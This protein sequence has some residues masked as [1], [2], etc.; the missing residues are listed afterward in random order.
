LGWGAGS[1]SAE[2]LAE[3]LAAGRCP[4]CSAAAAAARAL[5]TWSGAEGRTPN[6]L[7]DFD[8]LCAAHLWD[9]AWIAPRAAMQALDETLRSWRTSVLRLPPAEALPAPHLA[10]RVLEMARTW[11]PRLPF[12]PGSRSAP[13]LGQ[14][15][16]RCVVPG[17]SVAAAVRSALR[18]PECPA[19]RTMATAALRTTR[20]IE[21][22]LL[23]AAGQEQYLRSGGLCLRHLEL[24]TP[25]SEPGS[26]ALER[27]AARVALAGWEL[28]ESRRK[29]AWSSRFEPGG[30]EGTAWRRAIV[31]AVGTACHERDVLA[32]EPWSSVDAV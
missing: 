20:L 26:V 16:A 8:R 28:E 4:A 32:P 24:L 31:L 12:L 1:I 5:L 2:G 18:P 30:P 27:A 3:E 25:H 9:A 10:N 23:S 19:C 7:R 21:A 22:I 6:E 11:R 14:A 15:W 13:S 17:E 29:N